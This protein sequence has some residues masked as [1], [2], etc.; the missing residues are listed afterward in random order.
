MYHLVP[1]WLSK[2][3]SARLASSV[4][5]PD[6]ICEGGGSGILSLSPQRIKPRPHRVCYDIIPITMPYDSWRL[7]RHEMARILAEW[8]SGE[9]LQRELML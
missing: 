3:K 1:K 4:P 8:S 5:F 9:C 2:S 7:K 6:V